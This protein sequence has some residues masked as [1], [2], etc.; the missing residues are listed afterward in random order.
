MNRFPAMVVRKSMNDNKSGLARVMT[1]QRTGELHYVIKKC[2][3]T[4]R[5]G[6]Y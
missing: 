5:G 2:Y 4:T 3:D 6:G 1:W